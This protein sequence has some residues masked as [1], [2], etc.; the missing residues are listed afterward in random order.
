MSFRQKVISEL[1]RFGCSVLSD[2][3][4]TYMDYSFTIDFGAEFLDYPGCIF[5]TSG[6]KYGEENI[7][8]IIKNVDKFKKM[9]FQD[10]CYVI[11]YL[12]L[13]EI[14]WGEKEK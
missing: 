12:D 9:D 8:L 2:D 1:T 3:F 10:D 5:G 7:K 4:I 11:R 13:K 14:L 6:N